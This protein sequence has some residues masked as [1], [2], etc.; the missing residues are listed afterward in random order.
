MLYSPVDIARQV[1]SIHREVEY[2]KKMLP[3]FVDEDEDGRDF[4][5]QVK[6]VIWQISKAMEKIQE[7]H[8]DCI[9]SNVDVVSYGEWLK[10]KE[11]L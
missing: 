7:D 6:T 5:V 1:I 8:L 4:L 2:I 10:N 11:M 9:L 3:I